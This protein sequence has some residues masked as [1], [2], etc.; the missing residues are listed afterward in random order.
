MLLNELIS[1]AVSAGA[2]DVHV[3][4]GLRPAL[5]CRGELRTTGEPLSPETVQALVREAVGNRAWP[6]FIERMSHD[7]SRTVAGVR[8][9]INALHSSR[10][11][12]LAIRI[13]P[14]VL[15]TVD[16]LNLHPD[17]ARLAHRAHGLVLVSGPTG[18][19]KSTTMAALLQ[20]INASEARHILTIEQPVEY[21]LVPQQAYVRQREVG[22]D[23]PSFEQALLD[24]M[25]QDPD[26]I[27]VGEMRDPECMRLTLNA[28][29][30]GHLVLATVHSS[31]VGEA[32][33][34]MVLAFPAEIQAGISAQLADCLVAVVCQ[35]LRYHEDLD[36]RVP[37]LEI[38]IGNT[39]AR[40]CIRQQQYFKLGSVIDTGASDG[41]W[42]WERY[43]AWLDAR[44]SWQR[45]AEL[46]ATPA[47]STTPAPAHH[48]ASSRPRPASA[49]PRPSVARDEPT[50]AVLVIDPPE[51][52]LKEILSELERKRR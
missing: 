31:S 10:G 8:C 4:P 42:S 38:L 13:L 20:E 37:E 39:A 17:L 45:P 19:G 46:R 26:V 27:M 6:E 49:V 32:I 18:C 35:R 52:E 22:R 1:Q 44:T 5:R 41:M 11:A 29:E 24:A 34:R 3:E 25:R 51:V 47:E 36:L 28:A 50:D 40:A 43:R 15:P 12:G 23:T 21:C 16:A 7:S 9:R 33:Q 2:S 30:T 14:G 48:R